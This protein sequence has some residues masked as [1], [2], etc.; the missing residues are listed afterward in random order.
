M[1]FDSNQPLN[2]GVTKLSEIALDRYQDLIGAD[3]GANMLKALEQHLKI[4]ADL[5]RR[6]NYILR[7]EG[8]IIW[9]GSEIRL[10]AGS[11]TNHIAFE[12]LQTE[13]N[14]QRK[15]TLYL[16]GST[17]GNTTNTFQNIPMSDGDLLYLELDPLK[18]VG[19]TP[20]SYSIQQLLGASYSLSYTP[21]NI[22]GQSFTTVAAGNLNSVTFK[23]QK[24]GATVSGFV[25]F[26]LRSD[27]LGE[28]GALI[29]TS[30][31]SYDLSSIAV[32]P[33]TTDVTLSFNLPYLSPATKYWITA[34][35]TT[36]DFTDGLRYMANTS[37]DNY[38]SGEFKM[39]QTGVWD[40]FQNN[41]IYSTMDLYFDISINTGVPSNIDLENAVNGGSIV[42]GMTVKK[43]PLSD[44]TGIPKMQNP[45]SGTATTFFI[46]LALRRGTNIHWIP[47][48]I[49]WPTGSVSQ[50]G[51]VIVSGIEAYPEYFVSNQTELL[52]ALSGLSG[53]GGVILV[54][55]PITIDQ[56]VNVP[57]NVKILGRGMGKNQITV[58]NGGSISLGNNACLQ[59]LRIVAN[60]GFTGEMISST[61]VRAR[62]QDCYI[63]F[64]NPTDVVGNIAVRLQ[65]S[66]HRVK[67][68]RILGVASATNKSGIDF[69]GGFFSV[70]VDNIF[71]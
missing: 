58:V 6:Q 69:S 65:G 61:S 42:Q 45:I 51:A 29:A 41:P 52:T 9:N 59:D 2:Q 66:Y 68:C 23:L 33:G 46:P 30:T 21:T 16:K 22:E 49:M 11:L 35:Y 38:G 18:V 28:P 5:L 24:A 43:V 1:T 27:N 44:V 4:A 54:K 25:E 63:D 57:A 17:T 3:S 8:E 50:L 31:S 53:S 26:E 64:T 48:G 7:S 55:A 39:K 56:A 13:S 60:V 20:S 32:A 36:P 62:I 15:A 37:P 19:D 47:H 70:E 10:D 40:W 14:N 67:D 71:T 12:I 34:K